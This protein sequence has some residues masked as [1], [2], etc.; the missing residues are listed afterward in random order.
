MDEADNSDRIAV[1]DHG[2]IVALDTP[3]ALKR[4][5]G[6][7]VLT[8]SSRNNDSVIAALS[9]KYSLVG[10][11][12]NGSVSVKVQNGEEFLPKFVK[13]YEGSIQTIGLRRPTL[14]DVFLDLT[15]REIRNESVGE[16]ELM[17][18]SMRGR[19]RN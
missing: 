10:Q 7:D 16:R 9:A 8:I 4:R 11:E 6:G 5:V 3:E 19:R 18:K 13:E 15:G 1:I 17:S 2:E 12:K 14:E